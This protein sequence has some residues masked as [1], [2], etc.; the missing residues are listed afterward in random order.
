MVKLDHVGIYVADMKKS[1]DFYMTLFGFSEYTRFQVDEAEI[2]VLKVGD[3]LIELIQRP[4][5]PGKPP[6]GN[7]CHVALEINDYDKIIQQ[8]DDSEGE[9]RKI[10]LND[11][12]RIAFFK[13]PDGHTIEIMEK[14]I[15]N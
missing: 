15:G 7:W 3:N 1:K 9:L 11:G 10:T 5:S 12:S 2:V 14:G 8:I 6:Q 4:E 13:D